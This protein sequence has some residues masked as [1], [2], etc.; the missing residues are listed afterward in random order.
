[1]N[2]DSTGLLVRGA[3]G[4]NR[5]PVSGHGVSRHLG[6]HLMRTLASVWKYE[7]S[8]AGV[9][10]STV[11]LITADKQLATVTATHM[12]HGIQQLDQEANHGG[13]GETLIRYASLPH[14]LIRVHSAAHWALRWLL[15]RMSA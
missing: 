7:Q 3:E 6:T 2:D 13:N 14:Q 12:Q 11:R 9:Q 10:N 5:Q 4:P 8:H 1:M 15:I